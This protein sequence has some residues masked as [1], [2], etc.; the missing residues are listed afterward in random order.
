LVTGIFGVLLALALPAWAQ[1]SAAPPAATPA[2]TAWL[3]SPLGRVLCA[4]VVMAA[5]EA[6]K[7]WRAFADAALT[8]PLAR[9]GMAAVLALVSAVP[10]WATGATITEALTLALSSWLG[11]MGLNAGIGALKGQKAAKSEASS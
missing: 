4:A 1:E 2:F 9:L 6:L 10:V 3:L 7:Q 5:L 8:H 11:S